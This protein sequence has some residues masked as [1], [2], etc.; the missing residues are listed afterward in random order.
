MTCAGLGRSVIYEGH[1]RL[2]Q[3][4]AGEIMGNDGD[5][6]RTPEDAAASRYDDELLCANWNPVIALVE[7]SCAKPAAESCHTASRDIREDDAEAFLGR[8]Y[9][10]GA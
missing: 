1:G 10:F 2:G 4:G 9:T 3:S 7:W 5:G 6:K 8:F